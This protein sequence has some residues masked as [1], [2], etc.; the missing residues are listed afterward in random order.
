MRTLLFLIMITGLLSCSDNKAFEGT[1]FINAKV[2]DGNT[3]IEKD[4]YV[5]NGIFKFQAD[6]EP[7]NIIDLKNQ[8]VIPPFGDAHTHNFDD[9]ST[10]DSIY[11]AYINEG[12]FYVQ[13]LTNHH[14]IYLKLKDSLNAPGK[15]AVAFAHGGITS[16][17]GHPHNLYESQA[18]NYSWRAMFD[19]VKK[20]SLIR[21]KIKAND[22][23]NRVKQEKG[24]ITF[25][26]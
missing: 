23:Y 26:P 19:P 8:F 7:S 22:A 20:D 5:D 4:F 16:T 25:K 15:I 11:R 9:I 6:G 13:V 2:F 14:S 18:L 1:Q 3:F 12:V 10:F 21:S 24:I 17:G